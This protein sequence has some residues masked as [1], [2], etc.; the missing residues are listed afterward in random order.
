M[1]S[2]FQQLVHFSTLSFILTSLF[3]AGL[4]LAF[5]EI[6]TPLK[7]MKMVVL[8]LIINFLLI[9]LLAI[10]ISI[11]FNADPSLNAGLIIIACA[12]GAPFLPKLVVL[13]KGNE[14]YSIGIMVLLMAGTVIFLPFAL[15]LIIP[16]L[17]VN[18]WAIAKPLIFLMLLPLG[19]GLLL[20]SLK[21]S[22]AIA[23]KPFV[24]KISSISLV[25]MGI[26]ALFLDYSVFVNAW[27]TGVYATTAW[28][29]VG[30]LS[31]GYLFG[32]SGQEGK[33][34]MMLASGSRN[35]AAALIIAVS[36][37]PD[38]R[39]GTTVLIGSLV[40]FIF[41]FLI[42]GIYGKIKRLSSQPPC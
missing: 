41:L 29:S 19:L 33:L 38:Q 1:R 28:L 3:G 18:P 36:N 17:S 26:S 24:M 37:F 5:K 12:A 25:L 2:I 6:L 13:A 15:P 31:L 27:G 42:A 23:A 11:L 8:A 32:G 7:N 10:G 39:V 14:A 16:G 22:L 9:P 35:I 21:A 20:K 4:G 30:A 40:Q 34:V